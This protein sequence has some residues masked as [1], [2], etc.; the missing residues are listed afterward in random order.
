MNKLNKWNWLK[1]YMQKNNISQG[2][3]A[4]AL[5]WQKPRVSELLCGKR[6]FPGSKVYL[7]AQFFNLDLEELTKYN[8]GYS[9]E[10]PSTDGRKPIPRNPEQITIDI[11]DTA[12]VGDK[13]K[14][15]PPLGQQT[16][17]LPVLRRL[18]EVKPENIRIFI[19]RGDSMQP[20]ISDGDMVWADVSVKTPTVDGL[21]L[22]SIQGE[23]FVKRLAVDTFNHTASI[24]SDNNLYPPIHVNH[25]EKIEVLGKVITICKMV[26]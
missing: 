10:I 20:T 1:E 9:N 25:P 17:S 14:N 7:A 2:E 22:F 11:L 5:R 12:D 13:V 3:V 15:T 24:I 4:E 8:S 19:T 21:Y 26:R 6:D 18:T 16:I 23:V